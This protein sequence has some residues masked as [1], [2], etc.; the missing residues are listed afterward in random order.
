MRVLCKKWQSIP[1]VISEWSALWKIISFELNATASLWAVYD[2][3]KL[4][5]HF[6]P[7]RALTSLIIRDIQP[8]CQSQKGLM[9]HFSMVDKMRREG[10]DRE[11]ASFGCWVSKSCRLPRFSPLFLLYSLLYLTSIAPFQRYGLLTLVA[12]STSVTSRAVNIN[13]F[14]SIIRLYSRRFDA[15]IRPQEYW[16]FNIFIYYFIFFFTVNSW[17]IAMLDLHNKH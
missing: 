3:R 13:R 5:A 12:T 17:L 4:P 7:I 6:W 8:V 11:G 15:W 10:A 2:V 1:L 16:L 14:V 9:Q